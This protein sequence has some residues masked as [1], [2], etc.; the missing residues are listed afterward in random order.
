MVDRGLYSTPH[1]VNLGAPSFLPFD[2]HSCYRIACYFMIY[3]VYGFSCFV[4]HEC[5]VDIPAGWKRIYIFLP[6]NP[7]KIGRHAHQ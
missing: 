2:C 1:M 4:E 5:R 7:L 6:L 3:G